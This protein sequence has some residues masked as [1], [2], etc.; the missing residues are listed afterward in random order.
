MIRGKWVFGC[1]VALWL[2]IFQIGCN[3]GPSYADLVTI[4]NEELETLDR[5]TS[6]RDKLQTQRTVLTEPSKREKASNM[7]QGILEQAEALKSQNEEKLPADANA[8][9]DRAIENA[10]QAKVIADQALNAIAAS[11]NGNDDGGADR[12]AEIAKIDAEL[13]KLEKEIEAQQARVDR[14][15]EKRDAAAE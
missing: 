10:N 3:Q 8:L 14:A 7:L 11:G 9:A 13:A 6:Q 4:Y 2:T 12:T 5:L 15:K 1:I